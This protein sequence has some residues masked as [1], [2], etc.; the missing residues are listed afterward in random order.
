MSGTGEYSA[1]LTGPEPFS[2][3]CSVF[4][5]VVFRPLFEPQKVD[6]SISGAEVHIAR[7]RIFGDASHRRRRPLPRRAPLQGLGFESRGWGKAAFEN[8][9]R[10]HLTFTW[11]RG[12][13]PMFF[14]QPLQHELCS[15][16]VQQGCFTLILMEFS[17]APPSMPQGSGV[18][19][20]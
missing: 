6:L 15:L 14:D 13:L 1:V 18:A 2:T 10:N 9:L 8:W 5:R 3:K 19:P 16:G 11:R 17:G 7:R 20:P 4:R 12:G